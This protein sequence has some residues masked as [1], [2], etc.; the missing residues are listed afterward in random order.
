[1]AEI[2]K[3]TTNPKNNEINCFQ[4]VLNL[5]LSYQNIKKDLQRI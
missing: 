4:Y 3:S 2:K 5:A 1:M